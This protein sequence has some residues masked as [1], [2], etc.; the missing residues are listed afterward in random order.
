M[1]LATLHWTE[2]QKLSVNSRVRQRTRSKLIQ[3]LEAPF[4]ILHTV[5]PFFL[6]SEP[7]VAY[8]VT[9]RGKAIWTVAYADTDIPYVYT[10]SAQYQLIQVQGFINVIQTFLSIS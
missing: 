7:A 10:Y 5:D 1:T 6:L 4:G 9:I 8:D 2:A 3:I